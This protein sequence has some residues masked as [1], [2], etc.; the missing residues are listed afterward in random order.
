MSR[1][2][3]LRH[4]LSRETRG[5]AIVEFGFV[6]VPLMIV[7]LGAFDLGY[8]QYVKSQLQGVLDRVARTASVENPSF[9]E[10]GDTVE[11]QIENAVRER[12]NRIARSA[13][14]D[15]QQTNY[16]QF[17]GVGR[18]EK[19]VTDNDGDGTFDY[20]DGDCWEDLNANGSF[21]ENAGRTGQGGADDVVFYEVT[22][23]MPRIVPVMSLIGVPDEYNI[24]ARTA[25]R[26]QPFAD[27][28]V[29]PVECGVVP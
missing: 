5:M 17:S 7:L 23:T 29:P 6:V 8:Q 19:L 13:T 25:I 14:Y 24:I 4:R 27:Q 10:D 20:D 15:I 26:N 22:V 3:S 28:A 11:E 1:L 9:S 12:V 16:Y 18:S 21:D 2:R